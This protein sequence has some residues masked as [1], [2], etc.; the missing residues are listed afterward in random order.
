M[1]ALAAVPAMDILKDPNV[2]KGILG[3]GKTAMI[4]WAVVLVV[5]LLGVIGGA[6][7]SGIASSK[8]KNKDEDET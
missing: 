4:I 7:G 2:Q 1:A 5:I 8:S 3:L 6:V